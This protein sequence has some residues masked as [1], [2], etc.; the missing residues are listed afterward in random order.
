V[1]HGLKVFAYLLDP[2]KS[3]A[4]RQA[5]MTGVV[6]EAGRHVFAE[7][8]FPPF[9]FIL[10]GDEKPIYATLLDIT[11]MGQYQFFLH[12]TLFLKLPVLPVNT[13]LPGDFRTKKEIERTIQE[14]KFEGRVELD[15]LR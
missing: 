8:A 6:N 14:N 13:W 3:E 10:T 1:P 2:N 11:F 7:V 9:G 12:Q 5:G 15:V 4:Y